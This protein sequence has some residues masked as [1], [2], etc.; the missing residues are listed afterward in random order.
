MGSAIGFG[1]RVTA[2]GASRPPTL[3]FGTRKPDAEPIN[4]RA[5]ARERE[6]ERER[7]FP[8]TSTRTQPPSP[9]A[10]FLATSSGTATGATFTVF[11]RPLNKLDS[12][13]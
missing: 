11:T 12:P 3:G 1:K 13:T 4:A 6:R 5:R 7:G 2:D 10:A 9:H 8:I